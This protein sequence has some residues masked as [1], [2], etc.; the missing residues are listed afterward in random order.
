MASIL[1]HARGWRAQIAKQ[2]IRKSRLFSTKAR[3]MAWAV[4]TER[5]IEEGKS[6]RVP[7]KSFGDLLARYRDEVSVAKRGARWESMRIDAT[8]ARDALARVR[9]RE[10]NATHIAA[11]RDARLRVVSAASVRRE[12]NL[13]SHACGIAV[14]EWNW[15]TENPMKSVRRPAPAQPRDRRI[16]EDEITRLLFALGYDYAA[17]PLTQT[18]RVGAAMLFSIESAMRAGEIVALRWEQIDIERR[19]ARLLRTKN[20]TQREVPLSREALRLLAQLDPITR[21]AGDAAFGLASTQTL[22]AL[23]RKAK[24]RALI[25]DLH[26]HDTRHEAITRLAKKLDVL[27]L[28]RTVGHRDLRQLMIYYNESAA[29]LAVRLD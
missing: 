15:L 20:G 5:E 14:R 17:P 13:L 11:W 2:G 10:L 7:D 28:A 8:L 23:F 25:C 9:L 16:S 24:A 26:F 1:P 4:D 27:A 12:W 18:A 3:A 19:T 22:D 6:G 21:A 29:D